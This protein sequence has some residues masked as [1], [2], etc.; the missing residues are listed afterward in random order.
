MNTRN[1]YYCSPYTRN[2]RRA[3]FALYRFKRWFWSNHI[4]EI[5]QV[6][7]LIGQLIIVILWFSTVFFLPHIFH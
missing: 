1:P 3:R 6:F 7:T 2:F 4:E 5:K